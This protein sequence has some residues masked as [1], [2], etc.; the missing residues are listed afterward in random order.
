MLGYAEAIRR[1]KKYFAK[2]PDVAM[3]FLFGSRAGRRT[4][5]ASDWDI[6]VYIKHGGGELEFEDAEF[7]YAGEDRLWADLTDM[8]GTD[9]VDL[10]MLNRA[11][12]AI[13]EAAIR[14][15]ALVIKDRGLWLRFM[16]AITKLAEEYRVFAREYR[17]V[18]RRSRSLSGQ[19]R[20]RLER[21]LDFLEEQ[22]GLFAVYRGFS[23]AEY[24]DEPRKRNEIERWL[25][26][27]V[28]AVIDSAKVIAGS[29]KR[30]LP[31]TYRE[32][33]RSALRLMEAPG[34]FGARFDGWVRLRNALAHE[35]LD[36]KWKR[37]ADFA[38]TGETHIRRFV[39]LVRKFLA[40][41]RMRE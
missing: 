27:I 31:R 29:Q 35:Y 4:R 39:E 2:H 11:P 3:A 37:L 15:V 1:L 24:E 34:D 12:A 14:G 32:T 13:A 18:A 41:K 8:L 6:A 9:S 17:Q 30:V 20:E 16:L 33:V 5:P 22:L 38:K 19:D 21:L 25:E 28:N 23:P 7:E 10:V 26:N 36:I 40:R